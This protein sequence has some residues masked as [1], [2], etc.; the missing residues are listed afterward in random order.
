MVVTDLDGTFWDRTLTVPAPHL[1]AVRCLD[2]LGVEVMVATSRRRRVVAE[3]FGRVGFAPAAVVLD[4]AMG[5]DLADGTRFHDAAFTVESSTEVLARFRARG[6]DPCVYVDQPDVDVIVSP[7][8]ATSAAHLAYLGA[9]ARTGDLDRTVGAPGV[10][11]FSVTGRPHTELVGLADD[12]T[13]LGAELMVFHE[14]PYGGWSIVVAPP[15]VT[16]WNGVLAH[17]ARQGIAPEEI[18]AVGDG[19]NDVE[20]LTRAGIAVA[21]RGGTERALAAADHLIDAPESNGWVEILDFV[22]G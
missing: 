16:K 9:V 8:P 4:G 2:E 11:G 19:D 20:M 5:F 18:L 10:Y 14:E 7:T 13:V 15:E 17:A 21:V 6:L 12:L 3:H 22:G 1:E